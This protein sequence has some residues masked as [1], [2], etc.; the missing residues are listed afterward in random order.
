MKIE[1]RKEDEEWG[2]KD[3]RGEEG[4]RGGRNEEKKEEEW[5]YFGRF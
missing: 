4:K 3:G 2:R 5:I 1:N